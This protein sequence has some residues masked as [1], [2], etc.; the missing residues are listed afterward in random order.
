[1]RK[2]KERRGQTVYREGEEEGKRVGEAKEET[3]NCGTPFEIMGV[4]S[5]KP[6]RY[7][8]QRPLRGGRC[9]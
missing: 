6:A 5:I 8:I 9:M 4:Q 7:S 2:K 1:M 3:F